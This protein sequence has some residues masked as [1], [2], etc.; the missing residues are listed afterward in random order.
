MQ[1]VELDDQVGSCPSGGGAR[2]EVV[3]IAGGGQNQAIARK[4]EGRRFSQRSATDAHIPG[5]GA[6]LVDDR[7][8]V[9]AQRCTALAG[10]RGRYFLAVPVAARSP[11][12]PITGVGEQSP[13]FD[14]G[15]CPR[16]S[17]EQFPASGALV[18]AEGTKP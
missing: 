7:E 5:R 18:Q 16:Q 15:E 14:A 17:P 6:G 1:I 4:H 13:M 12:A 10:L 9:G 11:G 3:K 2:Q 8:L